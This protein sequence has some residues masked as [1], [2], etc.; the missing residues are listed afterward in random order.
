MQ[1]AASP[2]VRQDKIWA[3]YSGDKV[4]V[5]HGVADA[6]RGLLARVQGR[7]LRALSL[8]SSSEPQFRI[9]EPMFQGGLWLVDIEREALEIVR[10]RNERQGIEHVFPVRADYR[11]LF[12]DPASAREF[13]AACTEGQRFDLVTLHHS[14]YYA[15]RQ[16]WA[17]LFR[18]I[19]SELLSGSGVIHAVLMASRS[20]DPTSANWL[21]NHFAGRFFGVHN[22]QDL[23][24][25]AESL[26]TDSAFADATIRTRSSPA[27][28]W[29][30]DFGQ[31]MHGVWIILLHPHVHRF[32][33]E[34]QCEVI[35][36]VYREVYLAR[37]PLTQVQDHLFV[38][39]GAAP[40][41]ETPWWNMMS[42]GG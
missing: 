8:G 11:A 15:P 28:F 9:L 32:T 2:M 41:V 31:L 13:A 40:Q 19:Y 1:A 29:C 25:F 27:R 7:P 24:G 38:E 18:S 39:A 12:G 30:D 21:Y 23:P 17:T 36:H 34:Q 20:S 10:E 35:E 37:Q 5:G 42:V 14:M 16:E 33:W 6:I 3:R 4:D 22:D 26:R